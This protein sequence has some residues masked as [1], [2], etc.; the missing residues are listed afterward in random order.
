MCHHQFPGPTAHSNS[1]IDSTVQK[2]FPQKHQKT[3][4]QDESDHQPGQPFRHVMRFLHHNPLDFFVHT[5]P[6]EKICLF[7]ADKTFLGNH[8]IMPF[9]FMEDI[10]CLFC[11]QKIVQRFPGIKTHHIPRHPHRYSVF[12]QRYL[13]GPTC[14]GIHFRRLQLFSDTFLRVAAINPKYH[15]YS[16]GKTETYQ[17]PVEC[18]RHKINTAC[19]NSRYHQAPDHHTISPHGLSQTAAV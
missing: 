19:E 9:I 4:S 16:N 6:M 10:E 1:A 14:S 11:L 18:S 15:P 2:D 3:H 7:P 5:D 17:H 13:P 8:D 12:H